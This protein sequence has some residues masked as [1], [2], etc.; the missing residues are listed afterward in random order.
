MGP[1]QKGMWKFDPLRGSH[2]VRRLKIVYTHISKGLQNRGFFA[3]IALSP[4]NQDRQ[5]MR[6][7]AVHRPTIR[8]PR[9][10]V[11]CS[12]SGAI[13]VTP[14]DRFSGHH[15]VWL[16]ATRLLGPCPFVE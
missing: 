8:P 12:F 4:D 15:S 9:F 7:I 2:A 16:A 3:L 5:P 6:E 10:M 1:F 14:L 13:E 11:I